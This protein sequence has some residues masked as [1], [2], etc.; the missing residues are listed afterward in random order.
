MLGQ[1]KS[2][3]HKRINYPLCSSR[4]NDGF[5]Q[6]QSECKPRDI[7][8]YWFQICNT[9]LGRRQTGISSLNSAVY[10]HVILR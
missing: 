7:E 1:L 5:P 9:R 2:V 10:H 4:H 3:P 6:A 8:R